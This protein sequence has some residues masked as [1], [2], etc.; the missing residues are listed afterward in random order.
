MAFKHAKIALKI[1][2][3]SV[4][5]YS[6]LAALYVQVENIEEATRFATLGES[7]DPNDATLLKIKCHYSFC[8]WSLEECAILCQQSTGN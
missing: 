7:L 3:E 4:D 6:R 1:E 5:N 8:Q 2:P